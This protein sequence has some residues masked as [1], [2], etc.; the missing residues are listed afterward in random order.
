[1]NEPRTF[2]GFVP[3][4]IHA[5]VIFHHARFV[6]TPCILWEVRSL[7]KREQLCECRSNRQTST[8]NSTEKPE[9][10]NEYHYQF[11]SAISK[12]R[13][14]RNQTQEEFAELIGISR[15]NLTRIENDR[16]KPKAETIAKICEVCKVSPNTLY[17]AELSIHAENSTISNINC[18][19]IDIDSRLLALMKEVQGLSEEGIMAFLDSARLTY[20]GIKSL[21]M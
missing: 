3:L 2:C 9:A 14:E 8:D 5:A 17:P 18:N 10:K 12:L 1:M 19:N 16:Q 15:E 7:A 4:F 11:G 21:N 13:I 20:L 6:L